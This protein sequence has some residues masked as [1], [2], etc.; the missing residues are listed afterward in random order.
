[1]VCLIYTKLDTGRKPYRFPLG[2]PV[3]NRTGIGQIYFILRTS[4]CSGPKGGAR[5]LQGGLVEAVNTTL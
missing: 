4:V 5:A 3:K 1:M 2:N